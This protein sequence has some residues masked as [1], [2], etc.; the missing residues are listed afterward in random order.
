MS[1]NTKFSKLTKF[2]DPAKASDAYHLPK[3]ARASKHATM[4]P[5]PSRPKPTEVKK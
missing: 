2:T 5:L 3:E 4:V 1:E